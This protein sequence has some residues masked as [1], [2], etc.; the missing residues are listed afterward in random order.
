MEPKR[1][2]RPFSTREFLGDLNFREFTRYSVRDKAGRDS[3]EVDRIW[4]VMLD[5]NPNVLPGRDGIQLD[6]G[7]VIPKVTDVQ[8]LNL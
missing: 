6:R 1:R 8:Y 7:A 5:Q 4:G 3:D 2:E